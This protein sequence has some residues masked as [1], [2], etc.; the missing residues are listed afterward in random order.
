MDR[1]YPKL[2]REIFI[3]RMGESFP[4]V[5]LTII[6]VIQGVALGLLVQNTLKDCVFIIARIPYAVISFGTVLAVFYEYSWFVGLYRWSPRFT[7]IS[8]PLFLGV[9]EIIPFFFLDNPKLWWISNS[10][11]CF[12]A[13]LAFLNTFFHCKRD[14]FYDEEKYT[15]TKKGIIRQIRMT[16]FM[17]IVTL[18]TALNYY[19][20]LKIYDWYLL[21]IIAFVIYFTST[22][23]LIYKDQKF[24]KKLHILFDV[25]Y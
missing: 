6:S 11:F 8:V 10:I 21:E 24:I 7:D 16:I 15:L 25:E 14:M 19:I 2:D 9:A 18:I 20:T 3:K 4:N 23:L 22:F 13:T 1:A 17:S 5:Y 12:V